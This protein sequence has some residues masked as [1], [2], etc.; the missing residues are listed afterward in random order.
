LVNF[1]ASIAYEEKRNAKT[2]VAVWSVKVSFPLYRTTAA[3]TFYWGTTD[4][5]VDGEN[6]QKI[7][8]EVPRGT[9]QRDRGNDVAQ[10]TVANPNNAIYNEFYAH[11]DLIERATVEI[12]EC[13]EIEQGYFESEIRFDGFLKDFTLDESDKSLKFTALSDLSRTGFLV[14]GRILTRERC[15]TDFNYNGVISPLISPCG[16]KTVQGGNPIFCSKFLKG[17][18]GCQS[19]NNS[20]RFYA[21]QGLSDAEVQVISGSGSGF[22]YSTGGSCF[23]AGTLI[24]MADFSLKKIE[25]VRKGE[26]VLGF[27]IFTDKLMPSRVLD[28]MEHFPNSYEKGFLSK[29]NKVREFGVTREHLFYKGSAIF[30]PYGA[31]IGETVQGI[32]KD[33]KRCQIASIDSET[34]FKNVSVYNIHTAT[35]TYLISSEDS[36]VIVKVHNY[37][38]PI[39]VN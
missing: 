18:D 9:H 2:A 22:E 31:T 35:G 28:R 27:D 7:L 5:E 29:G 24:L 23:I 25:D 39:D 11:E 34:I 15:G 19:H 20:H 16:W 37:K 21:V 13:Y 6:F 3:K 8:T 33:G 1:M 10:F 36:E 17:V 38:L 30:K 12:K 32:E 26:Y 4:F 14:G